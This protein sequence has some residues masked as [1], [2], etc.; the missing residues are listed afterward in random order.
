MV[1]MIS[2]RKMM[3]MARKWQSVAAL[4]RK[5]VMG[6]ISTSEVVAEKGHFIVY[7]ADKVRFSFPIAY[8]DSLIF[9]ELLRISEEEFGLMS[10]GPIILA[11][12]SQLMV[13]ISSLMERNAA[14]EVEKA[15][16]LSMAAFR[17]SSS[18]YYLDH[19]QTNVGTNN[20]LNLSK[21]IANF[22]HNGID[23][24]NSQPTG[25]FSNGFNSADS[26]A[27][28]FGLEKSPPPFLYL[29]TLGSRFQD[30]LYRGV[31]FASGGAGLLDITGKNLTVVPL[32]EQIAQ[33]RSVRNNFTAM[34]GPS[35]TRKLLCKSLFFISI[36]SNDILEYFST[37][38]RMPQDE[39]IS[40]LIST[41]SKHI[42]TLYR[43]GAR[44]F[45]FIS[46]PPVGCCPRQRLVQKVVN[47]KEG[48]FN[49]MNDFALAFHSA[50]DTLL[51]QIDSH[52]PEINYSLGNTYKMTFDVI[53]NP[54]FFQFE[55]V[56]S[57]CCGFG[58]LNAAGPCNKTA[59][60]CPKRDK[61]LFWDMF[62]PTQKA[63]ELAALT[64]YTG[65]LYYVSPINFSQLAKD[66]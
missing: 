12:D 6:E 58:Y 35:A 31:N 27:K 42:T 47:G 32:S 15:L 49:P 5:R 46:V 25:R 52:L 33:F 28:L 45:G 29:L 60:L 64:L 10:D 62:H 55:K 30:N 16:L 1:M 8:L 2:A 66:N 41:Y 17:C 23:F 20:H 3:N 57:A 53:K 36:G 11:C 13:Y 19:H 26:L 18:Y 22:P 56:D 61:Y 24:P 4:G 14:K 7:T 40:I 38:N 51:S 37:K 65:P 48:C 39:Y 44:K 43:L 34:I 50:L 21:A 59:T 63:S 9:R 54:K